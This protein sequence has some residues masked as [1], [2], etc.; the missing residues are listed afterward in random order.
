MASQ[1]VLSGG[2]TTTPLD[3]VPSFAPNV[4]APFDESI[5]IRTKTEYDQD[6]SVDTAIPLQFGG[7]TNANV[8][9]LKSTGG[10]FK[11][12]LTSADGTQQSIPI[13][14]VFVLIAQSVPITAIDLTRVPATP[15]TVR[16]YLAEKA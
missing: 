7:V 15:T 4:D 16:V 6:L 11:A 5:T 12:K 3:G 13:D 9:I 14:T 8:V 10:K 1:F 2:Y